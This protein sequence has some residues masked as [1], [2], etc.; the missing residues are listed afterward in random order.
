[1]LRRSILPMLVAAA[2]AATSLQAQTA[3]RQTAVL[4]GGCFWGIQNVYA[5][6]KGVIR[7]TS[8]YAGG[9]ASTAEY[10]TV[11]RGNTGHAES[12][13]IVFDPSV[14]SYATLLKVFFTVAHDPTELN[15]QGP[16]V[17]T[18]YRSS[19]FYNSADQKR[20]AEAFIDSLNR[21]HTWPRPIVTRVD[22]LGR[23]YA[24]EAY[25][26]DY[27]ILHPDD[28]YIVYNDLPKVA[29]LRQR[30]PELY[31]EQPVRYAAR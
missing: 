7:V 1:V 24:A 20:V 22:P 29:H 28:G 5:H 8:G 9:D 14:V 2:T 16:D 26:Q 27:A 13:E 18:Q 19:V 23:F 10:E 25:H 12:V 30:Y 31:R 11:S 4:A 21:A 6:V 15:R 3:S 17:G